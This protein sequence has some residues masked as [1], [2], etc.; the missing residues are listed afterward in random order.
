[1]QQPFVLLVKR[2]SVSIE[3]HNGY[4]ADFDFFSHLDLEANIHVA[5]SAAAGVMDLPAMVLLSR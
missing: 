5:L 2:C 4:F 1:M 3:S